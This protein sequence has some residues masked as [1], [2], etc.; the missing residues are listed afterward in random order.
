[1]FEL[2]SSLPKKIIT[3]GQLLYFKPNL[4]ISGA[5]SCLSAISY[6]QSMSTELVATFP[7]SGPLG[8]GQ[9]REASL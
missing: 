4:L 6:N 9:G 2:R 1:M 7:A 5:L 3:S 8:G